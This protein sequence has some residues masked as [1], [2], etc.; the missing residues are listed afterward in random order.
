[1]RFKFF[2][3]IRSKIMMM[4]LLATIPCIVFALYAS[5]QYYE[6]S[7]KVIIEEKRG[8]VEEM[9][10]NLNF[11]MEYYKNITLTMYYNET[12]LDYINSGEYAKNDKNITSFLQGIVN[13]ENNVESV[14][15]ELDGNR[16]V[17]GY[18]YHNMDSYMDAHRDQVLE[19]AGRVVWIPTEKMQARYHW[20]LK[21]FS[22]A[23]AINSQ[24]GTV[25]TMWMFFSADFIADILR[26][27]RLQ[28]SGIS[29][30][31]VDQAYNIVC[32]NETDVI[33]KSLRDIKET[34]ALKLGRSV[35]VTENTR[36][37][38]IF[39]SKQSSETGWNVVVSVDKDIVFKPVETMQRTTWILV[40]LSAII[41]L[42]IYIF[43]VRTIFTPM[44]RLS[45][46]MKEVSNHQFKK[47]EF[48]NKADEMGMLTNNYNFMIDEITRLMSEVRE[49]E[50]AKNEEKMKVLS[51]QI[52]PHFVFN[53]LNTVRW[54][55][56]CNRQDNIK[57]MIESL[58]SLMKSVTYTKKDEIT[59]AEELAL[60]ESYVYIQ[61]IRFV[62]FDVHYD[63]EEQTKQCRIPKL[64][65]Q[66]LVENCILH[67]FQGRR[68]N[69]EITIKIYEEDG[70][71]HI[72][73]LDNGIGFDVEAKLAAAKDEKASSEHV[74]IYNVIQ[75]VQLTYGNDYGTEIKSSKEEG[76]SVHL[77][78]PVVK[79]SH[80]EEV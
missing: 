20:D 60:L 76:T 40:S 5:Y 12:I 47:I 66:P 48:P 31:I 33:G 18:E 55:A 64:L 42:V 50:K 49:E 32:S 35:S 16:Y 46:H 29:Y 23:R 36:Q 54:I 68:Q 61:K 30:Y 74:G 65:L 77:M 37:D 6:Y 28:Q 7:K 13:S 4:L 52:S 71:L 59:V 24:E 39:V 73:V 15:M 41:L 17:A 72:F 8:L 51:M 43:L 22:L 3:K 11:Q 45:L 1:M 26:Y 78:L 57:C 9:T 79:S 63:V 69:G 2:Y 70:L 25:G 53:T 44:N 27:E 21:T 14:V 67:A 38:M 58:I 80:M 62:N 19:K 56:I 75:R 10:Q 34:E